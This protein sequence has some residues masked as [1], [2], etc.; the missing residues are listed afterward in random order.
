MNDAL[1][2]RQEI[3]IQIF[4]EDKPKGSQEYGTFANLCNKK[5]IPFEIV[6]GQR[7]FKKFDLDQIKQIL[8]DKLDEINNP[9]FVSS[10]KFSQEMDIPTTTMQSWLDQEIIPGFI[11]KKGIAVDHLTQAREAVE[12]LKAEKENILG[13]HSNDPHLF[14]CK[15]CGKM[16][17]VKPSQYNTNNHITCSKECA[18]KYRQEQKIFPGAAPNEPVILTDYIRDVIYGELLGDG[19]LRG[20]KNKS[21]GANAIFSYNTSN[22]E[23]ATYLKSLLVSLIPGNITH[24]FNRTGFKTGDQAKKFDSYHFSTESNPTL[25]KIYNKFYPNHG[26]KIVPEDIELTP[27]VCL[28]WYIGDG[29]LLHG[30]RYF[31]EKPSSQLSQH[32]QLMTQCFDEHSIDILISKL[33]HAV[34]IEC[35]KCETNLNK[36]GRMKYIIKI[37]PKYF[38]KF[39]KYIGPCPVESYKYKWN[40]LDPTYEKYEKYIYS[41]GDV[42]KKMGIDKK[43]IRYY[44]STT[45]FKSSKIDAIKMWSRLRFSQDGFDQFKKCFEERKLI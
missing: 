1:I 19:C 39:L 15:I 3:L 32:I 37:P 9:K 40:I 22:L 5:K 6:D 10:L 36:K 12:K 28:H 18:L 11:K 24:S 26:E 20:K 43:K 17:Q 13:K 2:T 30:K 4:G 45:W 23:Y 14:P 31:K 25:T 27:V 8:I 16:F 41:T 29:F 7:L 38:T 34:G 44:A 42:G 35:E 21:S 33:N